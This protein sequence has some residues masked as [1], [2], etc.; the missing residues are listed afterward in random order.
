MSDSAAVLFVNDT[1]YEAFRA[2]DFDTMDQLWARRGPI[3]CIHP[4]WRALTGREDVMQSW[5]G[6]LGGE[7]TPDVACRGAEVFVEG[8]SA[9]VVCY[10]VIGTTVLAATNVFRREDGTWRLAHHQA[11]PCD[12]APDAFGDEPEETPMQ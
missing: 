1:F 2:R 11:G 7:H 5:E 3:A 12:L 4:G 8:D 10:E 9:F 6:I